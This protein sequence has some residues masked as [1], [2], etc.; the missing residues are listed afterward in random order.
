VNKPH[1]ILTSL[2]ACAIVALAATVYVQ[3]QSID[4][5]TAHQRKANDSIAVLELRL[6][7]AQERQEALEAQLDEFQQW[8]L[9]ITAASRMGW[10]SAYRYIRE[11]PLETEYEVE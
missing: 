8:R 1:V 11:F 10:R 3:H 5:L 9:H 4:R 7:A 6:Q 2:T